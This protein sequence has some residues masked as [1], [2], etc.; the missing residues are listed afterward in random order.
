M[1]G[2]AKGIPATPEE[3]NVGGIDEHDESLDE[4]RASRRI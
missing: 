2:L 1:S 4:D 3:P